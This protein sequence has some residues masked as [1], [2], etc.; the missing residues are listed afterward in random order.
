MNNEANNSINY[1]EGGENY[2]ENPKPKRSV[3]KKLFIVFSFVFILAI[4][5]T[6]IYSLMNLDLTPNKKVSIVSPVTQMKNQTTEPEVHTVFIEEPKLKDNQT[7]VIDNDSYWK[8]AKR[9]C[10]EGNNYL[11][12]QE[13]NN[14]KPL[15][16]DDTVTVNCN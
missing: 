11:S 5:P 14:S 9:V 8:I 10:G 4:T 12:V 16:T 13:Q 2:G 7:K 6:L 15:Y 3:K 1:W